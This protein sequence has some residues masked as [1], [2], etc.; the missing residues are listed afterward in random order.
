MGKELRKNKIK[1][2]YEDALFNIGD[3]LLPVQGHGLIQLTRLVEDKDEETL[4]KIDSVRLVFQSNLADEDTYIYLNSISGL[5]ACARYRSDV[6]LEVL[7]KEFSLIQSR[8]Q[9]KEDSD[10]EQM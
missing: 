6:V 4:A 10:E 1:T 8:K 3:P 2:K 9:E 5:V 7:T